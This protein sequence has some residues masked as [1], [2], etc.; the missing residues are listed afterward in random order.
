MFFFFNLELVKKNAIGLGAEFFKELGL[1]GAA[2]IQGAFDLL[3]RDRQPGFASSPQ[4]HTLLNVV[5]NRLETFFILF[6]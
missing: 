6:L 2:E 3:Q 1:L 5:Q 4:V